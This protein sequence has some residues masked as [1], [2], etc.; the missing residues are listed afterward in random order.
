MNQNLH[1]SNENTQQQLKRLLSSSP[2]TTL[3][4]TPDELLCRICY[5]EVSESDK[6]NLG[7]TVCQCSGTMQYAHLRCLKKWINK[8]L[9]YLISADDVLIFEESELECEICLNEIPIKVLIGGVEHCLLDFEDKFRS[10]I[11]VRDLFNGLITVV[12][13]TN[14]KEI[15]IGNGQDPGCEIIVQH[16]TVD[17]FQC[18]LIALKG[19]VYIEDCRSRNKTFLKVN[20]E[21]V[22]NPFAERYH[23]VKGS[24]SFNIIPQKEKINFFSLFCHPGNNIT[25]VLYRIYYNL[26]LIIR[27]ILQ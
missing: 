2:N 17:E 9:K 15:Y 7:I 11:V 12:N 10:Y 19:K 5:T 16:D 24:Y 21:F 6:N 25:N 22:I 26:F 4:T 14:Q 1:I 20:E 8:K 3:E 18:K 13:L 27:H 23:L